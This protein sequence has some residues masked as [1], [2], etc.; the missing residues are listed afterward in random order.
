MLLMQG[1]GT[2]GTLG[3]VG[4]SSADATA[5]AVAKLLA[6]LADVTAGT[7]E[8]RVNVEVVLFVANLQ[9]TAWAPLRRG[10]RMVQVSPGLVA[11]G[12][13][14]DYMQLLV[15]SGFLLDNADAYRDATVM[16]APLSATFQ[17]DPFAVDHR[18]GVAFFVT[19]QPNV[20]L[21]KWPP[22]PR[23]VSIVFGACSEAE[24]KTPPTWIGPALLDTDVVIGHAPGKCI[25]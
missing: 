25:I 9:D 13:A 20:Y 10:V 23:L 16:H 22:N 21:T 5:R 7:K 4:P 6:S 8:N 11:K 15:F 19:A 18:K 17:L 3:D 12:Y 1:A 2:S 14:L 24:V